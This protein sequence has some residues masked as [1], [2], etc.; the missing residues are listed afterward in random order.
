[1]VDAT[2]GVIYQFGDY[3][4]HVFTSDGT[5][6]VNTG[7]EIDIM[8][9]A[10][11]G[12][13]GSGGPPSHPQPY[14]GGGSGGGGAGG[15][16]LHEGVSVASVTNYS[17]V[18]GAG[19]A[20]AP[21][22]TG[23]TGGNHGTPGENSTFDRIPTDPPN[24][25]WAYFGGGGGGSSPDPS[26]RNGTWGGSSGG[27][28][29]QFGIA[30]APYPS[31]NYGNSGINAEQWNGSGGGGASVVG[32]ICDGGDGMDMSVY[33]GTSY[34]VLGLFAGG[35]AGTGGHLTYDTA[36]APGSGG[37]GAPGLDGTPNT[38]GGG[39]AGHTSVMGGGDGGSGIV[40]IRYYHP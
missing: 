30:A 12:G 20:G 8:L 25:K 38:G 11:G 31:D 5:F 17:V 34:G 15:L 10:G 32:T 33:F 22:G 16:V 19:G 35:G 24:K 36:G 6:S 18:V 7:G 1:V 23:V 9:V 39:G 40:M 4:V 13:G 37:G 28:G 29:C 3:R 21:A 27:P 26:V 2:G 14:K